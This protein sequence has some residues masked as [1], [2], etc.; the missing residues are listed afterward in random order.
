MARNIQIARISG[1][2]S[3]FNQSHLSRDATTEVVLVV[4]PLGG[5]DLVVEFKEASE[6]EHL[7]LCQALVRGWR[8]EERG[9]GE[10][11]SGSFG[12]S[13]RAYMIAV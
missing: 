7:D 4:A 6:N 8:G 3:I 11:V 10:A 9:W 5:K 13:L 1:A 2:A 12:S